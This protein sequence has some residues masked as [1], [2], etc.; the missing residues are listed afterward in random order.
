M[1]TEHETQMSLTAGS[2]AVARTERSGAVARSDRQVG[3]TVQV[4]SH[5]CQGEMIKSDIASLSVYTGNPATHAEV[6]AACEPL[7]YAFPFPS[8]EIKAGF[9]RA[10]WAA[11]EREG[12]TLSRLKDAVH[13]VIAENKYNTFR[14]A[15]IVGFD[16]AIRLSSTISG[17]RFIVRPMD[18]PFSEIVVLYGKLDGN[19]RRMYGVKTEVENSV[20]KNRIVGVWDEDT[21]GWQWVGSIPDET[22]PKRQE[23]FK[24]RLF[25]YCNK[26]PHFNGEYD[27]DDVAEFF[28]KYSQTVPPHD[29]MLFE[30]LP[31]FHLERDLYAFVKRRHIAETTVSSPRPTQNEGLD[32]TINEV[33]TQ[34]NPKQNES[35]L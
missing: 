20:Y 19:T 9:S 30:S 29:L 8:E 10:L 27:P 14:V 33:L 26:P 1:Q 4:V 3:M 32:K 17:L 24:Q 7:I 16:K 2:D 25:R 5:E 21:H 6:V 12:M 13:K 31:G 18:L 22:I 28:K 11:V 35:N 23:E 15:D 34:I